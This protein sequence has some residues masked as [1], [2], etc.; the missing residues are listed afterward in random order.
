MNKLRGKERKAHI[1]IF[2][3]ATHAVA[4]VLLAKLNLNFFFLERTEGYA[5][6]RRGS[7]VE[8]SQLLFSFFDWNFW[9]FAECSP[10]SS[11][12]KKDTTNTNVMMRDHN[13]K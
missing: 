1:R 11:Q 9:P 8:H 4:V 3:L 13:R 6:L 7:Y 12:R 5:E 2:Q 10:K